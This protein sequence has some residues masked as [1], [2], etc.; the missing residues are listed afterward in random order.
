MFAFA[1]IAVVLNARRLAWVA[2]QN[3]RALYAAAVGGCT[4]LFLIFSRLHV[5]VQ[6]I[7]LALILCTLLQELYL[8]RWYRG[9]PRLRPAYRTFVGGMLLLAVAFGCSMADLLR[10]WCQPDNHMFN[11][12]SMWHI[13]TAIVLYMQFLFHSQFAYDTSKSGKLPLRIVSV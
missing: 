9:A 5:P 8:Y 10:I 7:V 11:G 6:L 3:V 13:L 4:M 2:P 1:C 12:H